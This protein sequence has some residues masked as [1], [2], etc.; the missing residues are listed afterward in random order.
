[1]K[2][3]LIVAILVL[4]L[5]TA[6]AADKVGFGVYGG[7][8][9]PVAQDDQE[10]GFVLGLKVRANLPG[11]FVLEPNLNFGDFGDADIEAAGQRT[12]SS[13][14]HYGIDIT[15]GGKMASVGLKPYLFLGGAIY[16]SE[17]DGEETTNKSGWSFGAGLAAGITPVIDIDLRGRMNIVSSEGSAS[18]KSMSITVGVVYYIGRE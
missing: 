11:P 17:R 18:K 4:A 12:G 3:P 5:T 13:L 6:A 15:A 16:N 8:L 2:I 10:A 9:F 7:G 14:T 1:M